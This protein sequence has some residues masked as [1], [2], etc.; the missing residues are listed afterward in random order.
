MP[1]AEARDFNGLI[2]NKPFFDQPVKNKQEAYE[3]HIEMTTVNQEYY[4]IICFSKKYKLI[5]ID[6]SR[7]TNTSISQEIN[8]VGKLEE[9][10]GVT[11]KSSRKLF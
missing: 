11:L 8:T 9:D 1:L 10:D 4:Y 6:L 7:K 2:D 3:K 5:G